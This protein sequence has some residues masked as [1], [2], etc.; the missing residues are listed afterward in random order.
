MDIKN[1]LNDNLNK[2]YKLSNENKELKEELNNK[3]ELLDVAEKK[4]NKLRLDVFSLEDKLNQWREKFKKLVDYFRN[5]VSGLFGNKKKN[6]YKKIIDDLYSND[7]LSD[8][9]YNKIHMK[10]VVQEKV[11]TKKERK[12]DDIEL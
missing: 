3:D 6:I 4:I 8:N 7:F 2:I 11:G 9:D 1:D 10:P 5:K 12:K